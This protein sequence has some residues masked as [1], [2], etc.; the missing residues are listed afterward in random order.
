[1]KLKDFYTTIDEMSTTGGEGYDSKNFLLNPKNKKAFYKKMKKLSH[2]ETI[3]IPEGKLT[4]AV[5]DLNKALLDEMTHYV[6]E[7]F[8]ELNFLK[9]KFSG[10][11]IKGIFTDYKKLT[12]EKFT[13]IESRLVETIKFLGSVPQFK[14]MYKLASKAEEDIKLAKS[15]INV[16]NAYNFS[17]GYKVMQCY[18]RLHKFYK[19]Y[20]SFI[21]MES[22]KVTE[23]KLKK[24]VAEQVNKILKENSDIGVDLYK[25]NND[26]WLLKK[27]W[28]TIYENTKEYIKD[29]EIKK[30][31]FGYNDA[32]F[33]NL[34]QYGHH[35][36]S[37]PRIHDFNLF[38]LK[39]NISDFI[40]E[41][42]VLNTFLKRMTIKYRSSEPAV[43]SE[44]IKVLTTM[45]RYDGKLETLKMNIW[46]VKEA[47]QIKEDA[48]LPIWFKKLKVSSSLK[49]DNGYNDVITIAKGSQ[50]S[51]SIFEVSGKFEASF[52]LNDKVL[53]KRVFTSKDKAT[54]FANTLLQKL[55]ES[56]LKVEAKKVVKK[57]K[58]PGHNKGDKEEM[59]VDYDD[60]TNGW[61]VFGVDSGF[62][63]NLSSSEKQASD[64]LK[65]RLGK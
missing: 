64:W 53:L 19:K 50:V 37:V 11:M 6:S 61:G 24:Y 60:D 47:K 3:A 56:E 49:V 36:Q 25:F 15:I 48:D 10:S 7:I 29:K 39:T 58:S 27:Q 32:I 52:K 55:K 38:L 46:S 42:K 54:A 20:E 17:E 9:A 45:N 8:E 14:D 23:E 2:A 1:M 41:Y 31:I 26:Y 12:L 34:D 35:V 57:S 28:H 5:V 59:Y 30:I 22:K 13:K 33:D 16:N 62:C 44:L 21:R 65:N 51:I 4:E 40:V 18:E 43:V 63:Y